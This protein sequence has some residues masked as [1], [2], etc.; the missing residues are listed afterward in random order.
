MQ[1]RERKRIMIHRKLGETWD[2]ET[3]RDS[4]S[5]INDRGCWWERGRLRSLPN[6]MNPETGNLKP[7]CSDLHTEMENLLGKL[8]TQLQNQICSYLSSCCHCTF[9]QMWRL[10][11]KLPRS[12]PLLWTRAGWLWRI[13]AAWYMAI[14]F[15]GW[16]EARRKLGKRGTETNRDHRWMMG[17]IRRDSSSWGTTNEYTGR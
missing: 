17:H 4:V 3:D 12:V 11:P 1:Q 8:P 5:R 7:T 2:K 6:M 14:T 16:R 9:L 15:G 13:K 10:Y